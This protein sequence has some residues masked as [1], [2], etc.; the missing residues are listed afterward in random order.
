MKARAYADDPNKPPI[1]GWQ[2]YN[3]DGEL[4]DDETLTCR[5]ASVSPPCRLTVSLNGSAKEVQGQCGGEYKS[6]GLTS[7]GRQVLFKSS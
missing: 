2:F 5:V 6:T 1:A 4:L 7:L 3:Y